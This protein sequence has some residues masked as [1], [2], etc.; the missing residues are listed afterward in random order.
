[1]PVPDLVRVLEAVS[2]LLDVTELLALRDGVEVTELVAVCTGGRAASE[3]QQCN[4]ESAQLPG[5][6]ARH[7]H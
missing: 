7:A 3:P 5:I 6:T 4:D 2:E 1:V